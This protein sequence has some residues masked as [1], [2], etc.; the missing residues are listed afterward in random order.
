M[1]A[2]YLGIAII[3]LLHVTS[4]YIKIVSEA[5]SISTIPSYLAPKTV[6]KNARQSKF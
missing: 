1:L 3:G 2:S 5:G 6:F 4:A